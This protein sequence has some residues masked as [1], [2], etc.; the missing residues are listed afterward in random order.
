[1]PTFADFQKLDIRAGTVIDAQVFP[2]ARRPAYRLRIDFGIL[3]IKNSSAQLTDLYNPEDLIGRQVIAVCNFPPLQ[4]A[5]FISEVL[6]LG[7]Y[8]RD[9]VVLLQPERPVKPGDRIG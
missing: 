4:V 2:K 1:M 7:V 8:S 6:V 5:D 9:G 3:G